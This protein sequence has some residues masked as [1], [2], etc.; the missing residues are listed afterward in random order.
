MYFAFITHRIPYLV[1]A[2][3]RALNECKIPWGSDFVG[4]EW[5]IGGEGEEYGGK[6]W[7]WCW[8]SAD[9]YG[10]EWG[11]GPPPPTPPGGVWAGCRLLLPTAEVGVGVLDVTWPT[12]PLLLLLAVLLGRLLV[13]A[14]KWFAATAAAAAA[15][16]AETCVSVPILFRKILKK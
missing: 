4:E 7:W 11:W 6:W 16:W 2:M 13:L 1:F 3:Q 9:V 10:L 8:Y 15:W 12:P 5:E 14:G